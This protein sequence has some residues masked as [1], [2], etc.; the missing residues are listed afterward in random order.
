MSPDGEV[1]HIHE[2]AE[3]KPGAAGSTEVYF[4]TV[5]D[6]TEQ[7][8]IEGELRSRI[9]ELKSHEAAVRQ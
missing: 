2:I 4:G 5:Q 1:R 6:V 8:R 7:K 9:D 3:M